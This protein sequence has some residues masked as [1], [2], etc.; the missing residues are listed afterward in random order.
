MG[1]FFLQ[2]RSLGLGVTPITTCPH[3]SK[4]V[5]GS[6]VVCGP[7]DPHPSC[8]NCEGG[9]LAI[10]WYQ[11]ELFLAIVTTVAVTVVSSIILSRVQSALKKK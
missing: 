6:C 11:S 1:Q 10:P 7:E 2:P 8:E 4:L 9:R 5:D 3:C